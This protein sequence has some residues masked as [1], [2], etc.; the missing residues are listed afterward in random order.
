MFPMM[1]GGAFMSFVLAAMV[2]I[3]RP[4][5]KTIHN[6]TNCLLFFY[7]F[8][9]SEASVISFMPVP[10]VNN[11][12]YFEISSVLYIPFLVLC[13]YILHLSAV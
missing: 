4:Y 5:K 9:I 7:M 10:I 2:A 8:L 12:I 1:G 13:L 3:L 6:V 11:N